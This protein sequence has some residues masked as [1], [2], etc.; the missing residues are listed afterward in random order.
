MRPWHE[1]N[2]PALNRRAREIEAELWRWSLA[3]HDVKEEGVAV[4]ITQA[5]QAT[6][7]ALMVW[8]DDGGPEA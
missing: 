2:W 5:D 1:I 8:S 6:S 4:P 3:Q 7:H